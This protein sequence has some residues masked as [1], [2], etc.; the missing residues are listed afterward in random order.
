MSNSRTKN[1]ILT[2]VTG[3]A[4]QILNLLLTFASRTVFINVLGAEYL[5]L[6]G[7]FSNIL[8][9]L[10]LSE[11][12][13]GSAISFY[14][15]KP[16]V[17]KDIGRIKSLMKLYKLCYRVVG[18]FII[19]I[20]SCIMPLLPRLVNFEQNV[21]VNLYLVYF[22]Y[23]LNTASS[24]L[25]FAYKQALVTAN[26][27]Q[28][29]IEKVNI[30]FT[31]VNCLGDIVIL[32]IFRNYI[33]YLI[34]KFT[35]SLM[36]NVA[37]AVKIDNEYPYIK[38]KN[39]DRIE[40]KEI[41]VF[42]KD[43]LSIALFKVGS[44]L[45]NATDNIIISVLLGTVFVG[46]YS[47]Y[48]LIISQ[49][50]AVISMINKSLTAGIGNV[51]AKESKEKQYHIFKQLDFGVFAFSLICTVCLFQLL[52]S[53]VKI[54]IGNQDADYVLSQASVLCFC[55]SFYF[56]STTQVL[57]L[58]REGSGNFKIG[59]SLQVLG[60]VLNIILSVVLGKHFG[61]TGIFAATVISK[62]LV[63]VTPFVA[64]ISAR[65]FGLSKVHLV[66][67]YY[68]NFLVMLGSLGMIWILG[69]PFH[70]KGIGA[71]CVE[72]LIAVIVPCIIIYAI[73]GRTPEMKALV[74]RFKILM[75][76]LFGRIGKKNED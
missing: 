72:C 76:K 39:A 18:G 1:S 23:L 75:T 37:I 74:V 10:A 38:D 17:T 11:L 6:N 70:M 60:G 50:V 20:G 2:M 31:F 5:G 3:E 52:N 68:F 36:K 15:Y 63:T 51:M 44:T 29:K 7:L 56:D 32:L 71:F 62:A 16:L 27:E 49:I 73:Y 30:A 67:D 34:L 69:S 47:N 66:K 48:F 46:Y 45:F 12:G 13:I 4:R 54:W 35:F 65:V 19:V 33:A 53:F 24:Y 21:P 58:F 25:F 26:Q 22:L 28:Y 41:K 61:L 8:S 9:L 59:R 64:N 40:K 55:I 43:V 57:N 14:L 42:F